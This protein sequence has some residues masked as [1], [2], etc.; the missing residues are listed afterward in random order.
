ME[1]IALVFMMGAAV[2]KGRFKSTKGYADK[3]CALV[4]H[5]HENFVNIEFC[6]SL[7]G[8]LRKVHVIYLE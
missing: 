2:T 7:K 8:Y 4:E 5:M 1:Y 6:C 3:L